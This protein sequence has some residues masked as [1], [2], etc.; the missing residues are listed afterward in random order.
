MNIYHPEESTEQVSYFDSIQ[1]SNVIRE[2]TDF[3][4]FLTSSSFIS[5][6]IIIFLII[7]VF[8]VRMRR[9]A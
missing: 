5:L 4:P 6:E 9:K 8:P 3:Y 2:K 7:L 1:L